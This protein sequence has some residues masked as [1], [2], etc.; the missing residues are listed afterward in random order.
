MS[1]IIWYWISVVVTFA[2]QCVWQ[3]KLEKIDINV[4]DF[5]FTLLISLIPI[6]NLILLCGSVLH[7]CVTYGF[8]STV[9]FK[10]EK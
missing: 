10:A 2:A 6:V 8:W 5:T 1:V 7:S 9:L 3:L 4:F